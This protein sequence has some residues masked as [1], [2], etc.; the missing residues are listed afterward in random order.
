MFTRRGPVRRA[1]D[2]DTNLISFPYEIG[3]GE[4]YHTDPIPADKGLTARSSGPAA[5]A[6]SHAKEGRQRRRDHGQDIDS[7]T[8]SWLGVPIIAGDDV[9]RRAR[10]REPDEPNAVR[11]GRRPARRRRSRRAPASRCNNARLFDETKRLLGETEQRAAELAIINEIGAGARRTARF[12]RDRRPR[13][14]SPGRDVRVARLLH[15][16]PRPRAGPDH[17][18][19]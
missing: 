18:P 3:G 13:R 9:H 1:Y 6:D 11:R 4:R 16:P 8:E 10:P 15:R 5:A 7:V 17:V 12:R 2:A 14:R 19:V